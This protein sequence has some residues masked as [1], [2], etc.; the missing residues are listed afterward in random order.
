MKYFDINSTWLII[1]KYF[2]RF[3]IASLSILC[4]VCSESFIFFPVHFCAKPQISGFLKKLQTTVT[5]QN[6]ANFCS[7][8]LCRR[9]LEIHY[10][11]VLQE[12]FSYDTNKERF[13]IFFTVRPKKSIKIH[14]ILY[15][16]WISKT[17]LTKIELIW[18]LIMK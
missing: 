18:P 2:S 16:W 8:Q 13:G 12:Y 17:D 6:S 11:P 7:T 15:T 9:I 10:H 3:S 1:Q 5:D 14:K 4:P